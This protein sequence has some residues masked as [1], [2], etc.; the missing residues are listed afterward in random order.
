MKITAKTKLCM[1]VGDPIG[2]SSSPKMHNAGYEALN[3]SEEYVY[4][5]SKVSIENIE[6]FIK[7][8]RAMNIRG[9]SC[10]IPHK[11]V[12]IPYLDEVDE[13]AKKIGA[14]NT[15]VNDSG[16]LIGYNTDWQGVLQPLEKVT[17]LK[18]KTVVLLGAGGAARAISYAVTSKG[19]KLLVSDMVTEKADEL[20]KEFGGESFPLEGIEV[21][22]SADII[23]NATPVGLTGGN[24]TLVPKQYITSKHVVFDIIYGHKTRLIEEA[25]QQGARTI[26]GIEM[27]LYQGVVQFK[28]FTGHDAPIDAM[29]KAII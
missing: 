6:D 21:I 28:L 12:V 15:I 3:I 1:V 20:A 26:G 19:A 14:V 16:K 17:E 5:A 18:N 8:V 2:H 25:E 4:V 11:V 23:I 7:G 9:V 13:V 22:Q 27:L 10:T 29:R 24:D